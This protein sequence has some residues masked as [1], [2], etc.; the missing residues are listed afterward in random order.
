MKLYIAF[1]YFKGIIVISK[2][3]LFIFSH[4]FIRPNKGREN[5]KFISLFLIPSCQVNLSYFSPLYFFLFSF[6]LFSLFNFC[7]ATLMSIPNSIHLRYILKS[8]SN[9]TTNHSR[10]V[11]CTS[12]PNY[13]LLSRLLFQ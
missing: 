6:H 4:F 10:L 1:F 7:Q 9:K 5:Y 12:Q 13:Y 2:V 11:S 8:G 3:T